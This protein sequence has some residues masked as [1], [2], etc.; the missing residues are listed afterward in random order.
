MPKKPVKPHLKIRGQPEPRDKLAVRFGRKL[1]LG[2]ER[3][4]WTYRAGADEL[5]LALSHLQALEKGDIAVSL[6]A[7]ARL[8]KRLGFSL[9][10][11]AGL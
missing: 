2:R 7:A 5:G 3:E 1:Q 6:Q 4:G 10:E 9:D 11:L 8:A